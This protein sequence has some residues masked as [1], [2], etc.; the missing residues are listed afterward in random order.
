MDAATEGRIKVVLQEAGLASH[1]GELAPGSLLVRFNDTEAQL[2][3]QDLVKRELGDDYIVA[4]NL[5]PTTPAWLRAINAKP[6]YLGLD[7]RGGVHFLM[8]VDMAAVM[9]QRAERY[10]EDLRGTLRDERCATP[11]WRGAVTASR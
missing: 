6:M 9:E 1:G 4:L 7:L 10:V 5:A 3:A 11:R 2:K 8:E